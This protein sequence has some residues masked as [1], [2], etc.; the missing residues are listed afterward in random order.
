LIL[1][2]ANLLLYAHDEE[3]PHH[4]E[5]RDWL[6]ATLSNE[7]DVRL[8]IATILAYLRLSTDPRVFIQP[9]TIEAAMADV[10]AWLARDNV[11]LALPA[12]G[13]WTRLA[14]I[15]AAAK[16][17]GPLVMDAHLATLALERG[18]RVATTDRD[19][20]RFAGLTVIDPLD[21]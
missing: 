5:A 10:N 11:S 12:D 20:A 1:V 4:R 19:F 13:H 3:S 9:S 21:G 6:E 17:R 7:P 15:A 14:T 18:A 8:G 16:A 2:D